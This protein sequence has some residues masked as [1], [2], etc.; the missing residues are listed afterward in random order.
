MIVGGIISVEMISRNTH[1][2]PPKRDDR[3]DDGNEDAV[4]Q[5]TGKREFAEYARVILGREAKLAN[6]LAVADVDLHLLVRRLR[7]NHGRL[8]ADPADLGHLARRAVR[9][10][11][12]I[13]R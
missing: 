2:C 1:L 11:D 9:L 6:A 10:L 4:P 13:Q 8:Y 12:A 3:G 5:K 7:I